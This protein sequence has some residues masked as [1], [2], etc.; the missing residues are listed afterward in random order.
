MAQSGTHQKPSEQSAGAVPQ[1]IRG[2]RNLGSVGRP[3]SQ[4]HPYSAQEEQK[5]NPPNTLTPCY[6][7]IPLADGKHMAELDS[8]DECS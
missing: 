1:P 2:L 3:F 6:I 5:R 4:I 7:N 8:S